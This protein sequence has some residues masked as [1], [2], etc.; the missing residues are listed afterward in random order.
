MFI[1]FFIFFYRF[2]YSKILSYEKDI[3]ELS[4]MHFVDF[5]FYED[6]NRKLI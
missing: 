5:K 6:N 3:L 4:E 2:K 1:Y